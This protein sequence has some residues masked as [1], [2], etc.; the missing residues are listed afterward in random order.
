MCRSRCKTV[1][2]L[3]FTSGP[4]WTA[5]FEAKVRGHLRTWPSKAWGRE[6]LPG[7]LPNQ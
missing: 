3:T 4:A 1:S 5:G 7:C 6:A 2:L